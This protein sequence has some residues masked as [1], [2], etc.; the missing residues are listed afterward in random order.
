[1]NVRD[2]E[3]MGTLPVGHHATVKFLP[4]TPMLL[5]TA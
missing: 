4:G 1:M 3:R 5:G 2:S